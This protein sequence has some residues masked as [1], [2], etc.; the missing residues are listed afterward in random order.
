MPL[1]R[2]GYCGSP[3]PVAGFPVSFGRRVATPSSRSALQVFH[4]FGGLR[5]PQP[6]DVFQP[7]SD[8]GVHRVSCSREAAI[9][10]CA[11]LP[12]EAFPPLVATK[13]RV[14][15]HLRG[16]DVSAAPFREAAFTILPSPLVLAFSPRFRCENPEPQ[17][18]APRGGS[19]ATIDR[20][21]PMM[22]GAP[23]G[24]DRPRSPLPRLSP[25]PQRGFW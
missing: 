8:P 25:S 18:L 11:F 5:L 21:Q 14:A 24:F 3:L 4:L 15:A 6:A 1:H 9:P 17:G 19:V 20:F 7:A 12:F 10:A 22:P 2:F 16:E 13:I 23:L